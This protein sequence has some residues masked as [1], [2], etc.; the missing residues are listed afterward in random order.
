MGADGAYIFKGYGQIDSDW[1]L[2]F[3]ALFRSQTVNIRKL[4]LLKEAQSVCFSMLEVHF[5]PPV[6]DGRKTFLELL[7]QRLGLQSWQTR[8]LTASSTP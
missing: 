2:G 5:T 6:G 7:D 1:V 3:F 8:S 4:I